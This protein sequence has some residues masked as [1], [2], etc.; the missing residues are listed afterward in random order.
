MA[1][2]LYSSRSEKLIDYLLNLLQ[3]LRE[4][5]LNAGGWD[6]IS[7]QLPIR[8]GSLKPGFNFVDALDHCHFYAQQSRAP[9]ATTD[10]LQPQRLTYIQAK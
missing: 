3:H 1:L 7:R 6:A 9:L 2:V 4:L 8:I 5:N 10:A